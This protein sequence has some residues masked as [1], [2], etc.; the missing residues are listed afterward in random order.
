MYFLDSLDNLSSWDDFKPSAHEEFCKP[1]N[2]VAA[3]RGSVGRVVFEDLLEYI[4]RDPPENVSAANRHYRCYRDVFSEFNVGV[5]PV[6]GIPTYKSCR[7]LLHSE[8]HGKPHSVGM[9]TN[10]VY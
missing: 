6:V 7:L 10:A 1:G 4:V 2:C 5:K 9:A 3:S 8:P